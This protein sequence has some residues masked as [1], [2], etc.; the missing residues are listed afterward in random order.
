MNSQTLGTPR[1]AIYG[2]LFPRGRWSVFK[3]VY[4]LLALMGL[5]DLLGLFIWAKPINLIIPHQISNTHL[6]ICLFLTT[7]WYTSVLVRTV[8]LNSHLELQATLTHNLNNRLRLELQVWCEQVSLK[9]IT[10][11]WLP[12]A[13]SAGRAYTS[14]SL[15]SSWVY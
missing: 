2:S 15:V 11:T 9:V 10:S 8:K 1:I 12:I 5:W 6:Y 4:L 3:G 7:V 13:F 14:Y